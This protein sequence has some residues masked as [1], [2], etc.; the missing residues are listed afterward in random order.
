MLLNFWDWPAVGAVCLRLHT[1]F[2]S[3]CIRITMIVANIPRRT[4]LVHCPRGS[5]DVEDF[6]VGPLVRRLES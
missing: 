3:Q 5:Y 1:L 6:S 2:R 4:Y